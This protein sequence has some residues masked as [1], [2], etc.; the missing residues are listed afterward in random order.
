M[1]SF[2]Y[3]LAIQDNQNLQELWPKSQT[4]HIHKKML[5]HFNPKLCYN[6]IEE[7]V[8][9]S[10]PPG[11][12]ALS[13]T[14]TDISPWSNGD[15]ATCDEQVL[16]ISIQSRSQ[17]GLILKWDDFRKKLAD[18]RQLLGYIISYIEA[19]NQNVTYYDGRDA[20]GGDG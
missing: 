19:T 10:Q 13:L 1:L 8:K 4:L 3:A 20:C 11:K 5:F 2:S 18:K 16:E 12:P 17:F 9:S 7:L 15:K 6:L 14:E